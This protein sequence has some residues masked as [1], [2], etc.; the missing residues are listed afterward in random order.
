MVYTYNTLTH[1]A[2]AIRCLNPCCN[3][4]CTHTLKFSPPQKHH[5]LNPC[6]NGWCTHTRPHRNQH[7]NRPRLNPCCNGWCTH[8]VKKIVTKKPVAAVLILVVMDGVHILYFYFLTGSW[9][10]SLNPCC[11]GWCTHTNYK[12]ANGLA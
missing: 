12:R 11:N 7:R 2:A 6:C 5:S 10:T 8:T 1:V 9:Y 4:W 3:G